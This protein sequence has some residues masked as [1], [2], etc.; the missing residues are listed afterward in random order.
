MATIQERVGVLETRV[1][2]IEKTQDLVQQN[3]RAIA[4]M[5]VLMKIFMGIL[6]PYIIYTI[7][8]KGGV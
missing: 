5:T 4:G 1:D 3:A 8:T 6:V 2:T 7:T